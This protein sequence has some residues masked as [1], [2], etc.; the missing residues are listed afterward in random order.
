MSVALKHGMTVDEFMAWYDTVPGRY[1]LHYGEIYAMAPERS[2]HAKVKFAVQTELRRA[3]KVAGLPCHLLPD[4]MT[5]QA[6]KISYEP[7]ALVY[8]GPEH[9]DDIVV[10]PNPVVIV[11]VLSQTTRKL[12]ITAKL[13]GYFLIPSV[14]HIMIVDRIPHLVALHSRQPDG[15]ILTK[16]IRAG[17]FRLDQPGLDLDQTAFFP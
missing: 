10:I 12:D 5:V 8:C 2:G 16:L 13:N 7:D 17:T 11:E 6:D 1:E 9:S 3:I 4:G 15:S 14:Q